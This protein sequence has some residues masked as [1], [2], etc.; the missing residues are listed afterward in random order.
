MILVH[1]IGISKNGDERTWITV[2][3]E[4]KYLPKQREIK[5]MMKGDENRIALLNFGFTIAFISAVVVP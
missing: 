2:G 5:K 1:V 4:I 3:T